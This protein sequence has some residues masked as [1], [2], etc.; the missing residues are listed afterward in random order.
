M[1]EE[2]A[3]HPVLLG[4]ESG[5]TIANQLLFIHLGVLGSFLCS[6]ILPTFLLYFQIIFPNNASTYIVNN[7]SN[8]ISY[9]KWASLSH[10]QKLVLGPNCPVSLV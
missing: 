6:H 2:S 3:W 8:T 9:Y 4:G 7:S 5:L 10:A 1:S